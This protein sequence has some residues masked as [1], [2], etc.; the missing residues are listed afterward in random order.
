MKLE[1]LSIRDK[2]VQDFLWQHLEPTDI[3]Y[4]YTKL[5]AIKEVEREV[6]AN[7]CEL[8]GDMAVPIVFRAVLANPKVLE[9]HIMGNGHYVREALAQGLPIAWGMGVETVRIWTQYPA[10]AH[11]VEKCGFK[12]EA[13]HP[14][15]LMGADGELLTVYSLTLTRPE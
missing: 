11:I 6:I 15:M 9:P 3:R 5:D 4:D 10:L 7:E 8:W 14:S 1:R 13:T 2:A 12:F